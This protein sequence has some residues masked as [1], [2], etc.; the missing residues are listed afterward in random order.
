MGHG[1]TTHV[2]QWNDGNNS[3]VGVGGGFRG[4][5]MGAYVIR[6]EETV[7]HDW[8]CFPE[9]SLELSAFLKYL[10]GSRMVSF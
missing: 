8:L 2:R 1:D 3:G 5:A 6:M 4:L 10:E 9:G 7:E